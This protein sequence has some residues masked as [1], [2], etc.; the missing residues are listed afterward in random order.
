MFLVNV[1]WLAE[2]NPEGA[3]EIFPGFSNYVAFL[4]VGSNIFNTVYKKGV[5][6]GLRYTDPQFAIDGYQG[7][8]SYL[9][10]KALWQMWEV[11]CG[12]YNNIRGF[13]HI[14]QIEVP[15]LPLGAGD[16]DY[17]HGEPFTANDAEDVIWKP[18]LDWINAH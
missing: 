3:S 15:V 11:A 5:P 14:D 9:P 2:S 4:F 18:I 16:Y 13:E 10:V 12:N 8:A 1:A 6:T 7:F 17:G